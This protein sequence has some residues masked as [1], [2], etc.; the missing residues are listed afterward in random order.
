MEPGGTLVS[1]DWY[2][3][4]EWIY[5]SKLR[6][7]GELKSVPGKEEYI[8][9]LSWSLLQSSLCYPGPKV[10]CWFP[11]LQSQARREDD[12]LRK[13]FPVNLSGL[14]KGQKYECDLVTIPRCLRWTAF[15]TYRGLERSSTVQNK[16][17]PVWNSIRIAKTVLWV[18]ESCQE[19]W[20]HLCSSVSLSMPAGQGLYSNVRQYTSKRVIVTIFSYALKP[21]RGVLRVCSHCQRMVCGVCYRGRA[22]FSTS[23]WR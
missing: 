16:E 12:M 11:Q 2:L 8:F 7:V 19:A 5:E 20:C 21:T 14:H 9:T 6:K 18:Q 4:M 17:V 15:P 3:F 10:P 13:I 23:S 1:V 22:F